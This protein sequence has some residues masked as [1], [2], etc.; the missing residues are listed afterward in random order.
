MSWQN[1]LKSPY[2]VGGEQYEYDRSPKGKDQERIS[3]KSRVVDV[4]GGLY[5]N[6]AVGWLL[7]RR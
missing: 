3:Q 4:G 1:I 5:C 2:R 7:E 6:V